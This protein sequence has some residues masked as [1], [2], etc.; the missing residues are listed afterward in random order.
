MLFYVTERSYWVEK[1]WGSGNAENCCSAFASCPHLQP[2]LWLTLSSKGSRRQ[3]WGANSLAPGL[4]PPRGYISATVSAIS[5]S[6]ES[7]IV[8]HSVS[9]HLRED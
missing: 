8:I 4:A 5:S 3:S 1:T 9:A 6:V 7:L 2:P